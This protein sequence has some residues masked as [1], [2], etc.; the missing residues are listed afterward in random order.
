MHR[1]NP[2]TSPRPMRPGM[3]PIFFSTFFLLPLFTPSL[4]L[5]AL[6]PHWPPFYSSNKPI[7][8]PSMSL[9]TLSLPLPISSSFS[10]FRSQPTFHLSILL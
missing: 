1:L 10:F 9:S 3:I 8:F 4:F 7:S 5:T 6:Q 2:G